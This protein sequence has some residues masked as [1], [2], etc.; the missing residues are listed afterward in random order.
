MKILATL[1]VLLAGCGGVAHVSPTV[2][3][4]TTFA[5]SW[6]AE[7]CQTLLDQRDAAIWAAGLGGGLSSGG[8]VGTGFVDDE[9]AQMWVGISVGVVAAVGVS[10][11][12]LAKLKSDE[13][14]RWCNVSPDP[15]SG[16]VP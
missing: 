16:V 2:P 4:G 7:R 8:G 5:N 9:N 6:T 12:V 13:L 1:F 15:P 3:P 11:T 10:M 14:E